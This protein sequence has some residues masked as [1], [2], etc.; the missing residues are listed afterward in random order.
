MISVKKRRIIQVASTFILAVALTA[1]GS[2]PASAAHFDEECT[3]GG[4]GAVACAIGGCSGEPSAC[5]VGCSEEFY[6]CCRC[7]G[8]ARCTCNHAQ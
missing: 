1:F 3:S 2:P 6:A 8:M 5:S 7:D 4:P